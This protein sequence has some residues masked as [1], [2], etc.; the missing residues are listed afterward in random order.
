MQL[1]TYLVADEAAFDFTPAS[2]ARLQASNPNLELVVH[3][4]LANLLEA[5][6]E[7]E[8]LD[9]WRFDVDWYALAPR[10]QHLFTPAAGH[11]WVHADP[12]NVVKVWRGRFHGPM[13]AETL[14]S[15]ILHFNRE[16][17]AMQ[18]LQQQHQWDRNRQQHSHLLSRQTALILGYGAIGKTC[19]SYL[20]R[21][22]VEVFAYQRRFSTGVDTDSGARYIGPQEL[23]AHLASADHVILLLPGGSATH[24]FMNRQLLGQLK[25]G[26]CLYNFGRGTTLLET[27]LLWALDHTEVK[28]AGIDV[29]EREPLPADSPLWD[30]PKLVLLPHSSCIYADY[31][32]LHL[33]ELEPILLSLS[34]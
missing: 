18:A 32:A 12:E 7:I 15:L 14:L 9:T 28:G 20:G 23:P 6:P 8:L 5:L 1:H 19:A 27:D 3:T 26:A 25:A 4:S 13:I 30:H 34:H 31:Q 22:G 10:L 21:L 2:Y 33:D 16:M 29:T 17:P 24:G 11:D